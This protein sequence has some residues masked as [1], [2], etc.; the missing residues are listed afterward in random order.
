MD[1]PRTV[2]RTATRPGERV[3][4]PIGELTA[5]T[6]PAF[7]TSIT[8]VLLEGTRQIVLDLS[9][10][11]RIDGAGRDALVR[12]ARAVRARD[13][14]LILRAAPDHVRELFRLSDA[15]SDVQERL[16]LELTV[17]TD[18]VAVQRDRLE[19]DLDRLIC[20]SFIERTTTGHPLVCVLPLGHAGAH[21][22]R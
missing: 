15:G 11:S 20:G 21:Q 14:T 1:A 2:R 5:Q 9:A 3:I 17:Q 10:T 6:A 12:C 19:A 13:A 18:E 16:E 7:R 8:H 4:S 22:W